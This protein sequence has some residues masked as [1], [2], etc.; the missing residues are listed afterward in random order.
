MIIVLV[1]A[2][3]V[4]LLNWHCSQSL[5]T[6]SCSI[7]HFVVKQST[8]KIVLGLNVGLRPEGAKN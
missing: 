7:E 4:R 3:L 1:L 6:L 8:G 2:K 5:S